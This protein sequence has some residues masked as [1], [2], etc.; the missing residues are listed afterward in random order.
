[1]GGEEG[2]MDP[3]KVEERGSDLISAMAR[4]EESDSS[5][6]FG[7]GELERGG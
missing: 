2:G 4:S 7:D 6:T 5:F 3:A 1:M